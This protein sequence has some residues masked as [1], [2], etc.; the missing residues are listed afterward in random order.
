MTREFDSVV[1]IFKLHPQIYRGIERTLRGYRKPHCHISHGQKN[2]EIQVKLPDIKKKDIELTINA[3][4][5]IVMTDNKEKG[6]KLPA[7]FRKILLSPGLS[8]SQA[9]ARFSK[10]TLNIKIPKKR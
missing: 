9:Q 1:E 3:E 6:Y 10:E 4:T 8:V 2:V 7:Y 5:L